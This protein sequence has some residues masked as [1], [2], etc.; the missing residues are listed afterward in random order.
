MSHRIGPIDAA[1][2]G[3]GLQ[4]HSGL[5]ESVRQV[6]LT[7]LCKAVHQRG[8]SVTIVSQKPSTACT[9]RLNWC[10]STGLVT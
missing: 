5:I 2:N 3:N 1:L 10:R 9:M 7:L 8:G 4:V 6:S